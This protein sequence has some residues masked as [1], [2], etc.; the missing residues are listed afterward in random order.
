M[1][2]ERRADARDALEVFI[3]LV[4]LGAGVCMHVVASRAERQ[5]RAR[6]PGTFLDVPIDV[7]RAGKY[8][9]RTRGE[10]CPWSVAIVPDPPF[11]DEAEARRELGELVF[12]FRA[13]GEE[14]P[15][16]ETIVRGTDPGVAERAARE[17]FLGLR[18]DPGVEP[19][20]LSLGILTPAPAPGGRTYRLLGVYELRGLP[21]LAGIL[22]GIAIGLDLIAAAIGIRLAIRRMRACR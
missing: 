9:G 8:A 14:Q 13:S 16:S 3:A 17:G 20:I 6:P 12:A 2:V 7:A 1:S 22:L 10:E 19:R 18:H 4:V 5:E 11:A 15:G 21:S